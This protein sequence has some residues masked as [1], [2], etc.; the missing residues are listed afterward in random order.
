MRYLC[1]TPTSTLVAKQSSPQQK[2]LVLVGNGKY[3]VNTNALV[4]FWEQYAKSKQVPSTPQAGQ[5][6][7]NLSVTQVRRDKR[8]FFE[9]DLEAIKQWADQN[10]IG[11]TETIIEKISQQCEPFV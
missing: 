10:L 6:L 2:G 3:Y 5:A 4:V 7:R 11:D 9:V 1:E 8:R